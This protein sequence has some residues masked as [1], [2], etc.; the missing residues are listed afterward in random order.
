MSRRYHY[1]LLKEL[2]RGA[3]GVIY[4]A[5]DVEKQRLFAL[6]YLSQEAVAR[7]PNAVARF[8][9]EVRILSKLRHPNLVA[10]DRCGR[11]KGR[12]YFAMEYVEG[13][14]L[15]DVLS[16]RRLSVRQALRTT[17][18]LA[19]A[20]DY[21]HR[22]GIVHRDLKPSNI[23]VDTAGTPRLAD[24][25]LARDESERDMQLT[26]S[27]VAV[28]TLRYSSPEQC[29]GRSHKVDG[30]ADIYSL[31][32]VCAAAITGIQPRVPETMQDLQARFEREYEGI[33]VRQLVPEAVIQICRKAT[34]YDP[35]KRYR[36][37]SEMVREIRDA[38][39]ELRATSQRM[40]AGSGV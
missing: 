3:A 17:E 28:G 21:I 39:A 40:L 26:A 1:K 9:R 31:G 10:V 15:A 8:Q 34:R 30:R 22:R 37:A 6:K 23:L 25:G 19:R 20:L 14:S 38:L 32:L 24:F 27:G 12:P 2:G 13:T 35:K 4:L 36:A 18:K 29:G 33:M 11:S 7:H 16:E 5:L